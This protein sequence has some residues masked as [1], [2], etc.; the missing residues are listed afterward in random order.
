MKQSTRTRRLG[1]AAIVLVVCMLVQM[2]GLSTIFA[3]PTPIIV[4]PPDESSGVAVD[5]AVSV[6][7]EQAVKPGPGIGTV[8]FVEDGAGPIAVSSSCLAGTKFL[9]VSPDAGLKYGKTYSVTIPPNAVLDNVTDEP[10]A[11]EISISFMTIPDEINPLFYPYPFIRADKLT[12][13]FYDQETGMDV[14]AAPPDP[15]DFTVTATA[16][17]I[18]I[19]VVSVSTSVSGSFRNFVLTLQ[20]GV[21]HDTPN[22]L[23]SYTYTPGDSPILD[24][25][26]NYADNIA[27]FA[28]TNNTPTDLTPPELEYAFVLAGNPSAVQVYFNEAMAA[29][30]GSFETGFT[31]T[32]N[33]AVS[34]ISGCSISDRLVN[35]DIATAITSTDTVTLSY[36]GSGYASDALENMLAAVPE[37]EVHNFSTGYDVPDAVLFPSTI[38]S[39]SSAVTFTVTQ[40]DMSEG[41]GELWVSIHNAGASF[42]ATLSQYDPAD[43]DYAVFSATSDLLN[44]GTTTTYTFDVLRQVVSGVHIPVATATLVVNPDATAVQLSAP[45]LD[46]DASGMPSVDLT[47][48]DVM[49]HGG[50]GTVSYQLYRSLNPKTA[51][52]D[53]EG[54]SFGAE[55]VVPGATSSPFTDD[56]TGLQADYRQVQY[57]V[58]AT[59]EGGTPQTQSSWSPSFVIPLPDLPGNL[60]FDA[61]AYT[62]AEDGASATITVTRTGGSTGSVTVDYETSDGT[63]VAGTNYTATAGTLTFEDGVTSQTFTVAVSDNGVA[64]GDKTVNLTLIDPDP[65]EGASLGA[66]ATAV[67]TIEDDEEPQPGVLAFS[68]GSGSKS[69]GAGSATVTVTRTGG[70]D[71]QV[72]VHCATSNGTATAGTDYTAVSDT[73]IFENG[74]ASLTITIPITDDSSQEGPETVILTLSDPGGGASLNALKATHTL[75]ISDDD[76]PVVWDDDDA[77]H[78]YYHGDPVAFTITGTAVPNE[79]TAR[80]AV[81]VYGELGFDTS[82]APLAGM[83]REGVSYYYVNSQSVGGNLSVSGTLNNPGNATLPPGLL[84]IQ[85][86]VNMGAGWTAP[87]DPIPLIASGDQIGGLVGIIVPSGEVTMDPGFE[88]LDNLFCTGEPVTFT[89]ALPMGGTGSITFAAGLDIINF[90]EELVG[91][92]DGVTMLGAADV[93]TGEVTYVMGIDTGDLSFLA[94]TGATIS[95]DGLPAGF[96][97]PVVTTDGNGEASGLTIDGDSLV[98][99]VTHFSN[100]TITGDLPTAATGVSLD[101]DTLSLD[102]PQTATLTATVSPADATNKAVTWQSSDTSVATIASSGAATATV[103]AVGKGTATVTVTTVDGSLTD[104]CTVTVTERVTGVTLDKATLAIEPGESGQLTASVSPATA[105]NTSVT[106][107]TSDASKATVD[108][109]GTVTGVAAGTADITVHTFDGD[110]TATCAVTVGAVAPAWPV[111]SS[112]TTANV[113]KSGLTL[114]WSAATDRVA[115]TG[116]R[117]YQGGVLIHT[118]ADGTTRTYAVN[119]LAAATQYTFKIEAGDALNAWSTLGPSVT[120]TT[121]PEPVTGVTLDSGTL[122]LTTVQAPATVTATVA[123]AN[124]TNKTI[125][126]SSSNQ[127]VATVASTGA[128]TASVTPAGPG[129]ATITVNTA[130][131]NRTATCSVTVTQPVTG[132][133]L[134]LA[135][136][137]LEVGQSAELTATVAPANASSKTV[138]W[139][140]SDGTVAELTGNLLG[141]TV[142]ALVI[143]TTDVTVTTQDGGREATCTVTVIAGEVPTWAGVGTSLTAASITSSGLTLSW[144]DTAED[145]IAVTQY[146]IYRGEALRTVNANTLTYSVTGLSASTEYTFKVEAGDASGRWSETGP[147]TTATTLAGGGGG[148]G[149]TPPA[150]KPAPVNEG[151]QADV[152]GS[153]TVTTSTNTNGTTTSTVTVDQSTIDKALV[154]G[155]GVNQVVVKITGTAQEQ[156]TSMSAQSFTTMTEKQ[157]DLVVQTEKANL[158]I[159]PN[160]VN[161]AALS[162]ALN[163]TADQIQIKVSVQEVSVSEADNLKSKI[164]ILDENLRPVGSIL[165]LNIEATAAG[166]S[167]KI[168]S[169]GDSEVTGEI[170]FSAA[171]VQGDV[172][173]LCV[174]RF[175]ETTG[176]WE[177]VRSRVD[178]ATGK[179]TFF[180]D[181]FSNYTIM[182]FEKTFAD[183][184]GHWAKA[185][186]ELMAARWV[187]QG[188]T[189]TTYAPDRN[190]I[191]AEFAVLLVRALGLKELSPAAGTFSDVASTAWYRG[192]VEAAAA[193]GVVNGVGGGEF[194]PEATI[195]REEMAAMV[196]RAMSAAK[197]PVQLISGEATALLGVFTDE[198][199]VD[200]WAKEDLAKAVKSGIVQ[201]VSSTE[202]APLSNATRA[203]AATMVKRMMEKAGL[204]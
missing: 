89:A 131:D 18:E 129:T 167:V 124:A 117:V 78:I 43:P 16:G 59:Y 104:T 159:P 4:D 35:L 145:N 114:N 107:Q 162:E 136:L 53:P 202:I 27:S 147:S 49:V 67:L 100:Y 82:L 156:A 161:V 203:E 31:V 38:R 7:F 45:T 2:I 204:L 68:L 44:R 187:V 122:N 77:D 71:G 126:W 37:T 119:G 74:N 192:S 152:T 76:L 11:S 17:N 181:H 183:L 200:A 164:A 118:T 194:A 134:N 172:R 180:T 84:A 62:V 99:D 46:A 168:D 10:L 149:Y 61:A 128:T 166:R 143:G 91:L 60:Q 120:A 80:V 73:L 185:D 63:G 47:W 160:A 23:V 41:Y 191:R 22:I 95:I 14:T 109:D 140:T 108:G 94:S 133:T 54:D 189:A 132:V 105:S 155:S 116:Y 110:R 130:D 85:V 29:T 137:T 36:G 157:A 25:A 193:A 127:A 72:T 111:G 92:Q 12:L 3:A 184:S 42:G 32:V 57:V 51:V 5:K 19:P 163:V 198:A 175:N 50:A 186:V 154:E 102:V 93:V 190:V 150:P 98:F 115:V 48:S 97:N 64:N 88:E 1:R 13:Q 197:D 125:S 87:T 151:N 75:T 139:A 121:S 58:R 33:G 174:Y 171:D 195:T 179:V 148:G 24:M 39:T 142:T 113:T 188:D 69:E 144:S 169:F 199:S 153:S 178:A 20:Q 90:R 176:M 70:T 96:A 15:E 101:S 182:A 135:A 83:S 141:R 103:T 138:T 21:T 86:Y 123:P 165:Q 30:G 65:D 66:T 173:K 146:R 196:T 56:L 170:P 40:A 158:S 52:E 112:V 6:E 201:G 9:Y 34:A 106:W 55:Q 8:A 81:G 177:P 26:G 28:V 79:M